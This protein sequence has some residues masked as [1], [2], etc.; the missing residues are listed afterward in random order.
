MTQRMI[1]A[2]LFPVL[3]VAIIATYAGGLGTVFIV[4]EGGAL[5]EVG[6]VIIGLALVVGVPTVAYLLQRQIESPGPD[7][8]DG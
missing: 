6:A 5:G 3:A 8:E 7:R 1:L 2:M 4:L